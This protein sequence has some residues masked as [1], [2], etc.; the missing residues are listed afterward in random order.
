VTSLPFARRYE[1]GLRTFVFDRNERSLRTAYELGREAV[2]TD[3]NVLNLVALHNTSLARSLAAAESSDVV[4]LVEASGDFLV[5]SLAAFEMVQRGL[6]D[7]RRAAF[8]ERRIVRMLRQLSAVLSDVSLAA[9]DRDS[10]R[11]T[12]Q[13]LAEHVRELVRA[14]RAVVTFATTPGRPE[15]TGV[16]EG[17]DVDTWSE[18]LGAGVEEI[19]VEQDAVQQID[20]IRSELVT[21]RGEEIGFVEVVASKRIFSEDDRALLTQIAQMTAAFQHGNV[22]ES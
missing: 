13:L 12:V 9:G 15:I 2:Q 17:E 6:T 5:E 14:D 19:A 11:E 3:I 21:S 18:V 16:A 8:R 20:T 22:P 10:I 1:D 4:S 7:A